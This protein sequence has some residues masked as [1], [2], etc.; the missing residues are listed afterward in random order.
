MFFSENHLTIYSF[1]SNSTLLSPDGERP[2]PSWE[3]IHLTLLIFLEIP[4]STF[5]TNADSFFLPLAWH[6]FQCN[7][8]HCLSSVAPCWE[9]VGGPD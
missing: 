6:P 2:P 5:S 9:V 1:L 8:T 7:F 3:I 4:D